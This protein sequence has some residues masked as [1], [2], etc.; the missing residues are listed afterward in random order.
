MPWKE[1]SIMS[2]RMKFVMRL[3]A[4]ERMTEL[5]EEFG[6]SRPTG[7]KFLKRY[8]DYGAD[9]LFD[10]S[11]KPKR[12]ARSTSKKIEALILETKQTYPTWGA[13]KILEILRRSDVAVDLPVRSTVH[14]ILDRNGLVKSRLKR[15]KHLA[16]PTPLSIASR[17]N[18]L[19][20]TDFKGQF[21]M[22]NH[23]YC[24]PLTI[25]DYCSRFILGCEGMERISSRSVINAF[26]LVFREYGL[27]EAI[28][29]DNG[30]PFSSR[31]LR[32]L[33]RLGVW[34]M[35]LGIRLERIEPGHPEQ[36]GRHERMHLTLKKEVTRPPGANIL[37]QQEMFDSWGEVF[38][39]QRPHE[40]LDMQ[41]PADRFINSVKPFPEALSEPEYLRHDM[42]KTVLA[43]GKVHF[44]GKNRYFFLSET[45]SGQ[46]VGLIQEDDEL[47]RVSFMDIDLGFLDSETMKFKPLEERLPLITA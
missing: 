38:N 7:Y 37:Q 15:R 19:W 23:Q 1:T 41:C 21:Q 25:T 13:A 43:G 34:F 28:R 36:N 35:R 26:E 3:K 20:C 8:D 39:H 4:G 22:G 46:K 24:Y 29:S 27:P 30:E 9:G 10:H 14:E 12:L 44:A 45:L 32:G 40:A 18:Q 11:R 6:I 31:S 47:W 17:P 2:A 5:C 42:T 33:S 16:V